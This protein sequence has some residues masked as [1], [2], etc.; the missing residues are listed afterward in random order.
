MLTFIEHISLAGD[1]AK[2]NDD[3]CGAQGACAWVID[4]ATDLH[5]TPTTDYASDAQWLATQLNSTLFEALNQYDLLGA[6][7]ADIRQEIAR[8][9]A[10][11]SEEYREVYAPPPDEPRWR[12]PTA[13]LLIVSELDKSGIVGVDL[14]D[15]RCFALDASG[16]AFASGGQG[17]PPDRE[18]AMAAEAAKRVGSGPLL[19][20]AQTLDVLRAQRA[21]HNTAGSYWVFGL[22]PECADHARAWTLELQRPAHLLLCTDGF[23]ALVDR[24]AAYDA[25]GL[26]RAALERGLQDL[27]RE[28]RAIEADDHGGARHPRWKRSDDATALLLR[29]S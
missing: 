18:A 26:V 3:A 24:Y 23:S 29:L 12:S 19:R 4:G 7:E 20:D 15:C 8:A 5:D 21:T 17:R 14:G 6:D 1:R 22:Q 10:Q 11:V 13:A 9:S 27:G 28:L 16:A 2:Q 25:G